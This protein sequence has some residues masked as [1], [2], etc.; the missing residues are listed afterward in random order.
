MST[1]GYTHAPIKRIYQALS[2]VTKLS[3][4]KRGLYWV[5]TKN[6]DTDGQS[7]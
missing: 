7:V 3:R 1:E 4:H 6:D 5:G 2:L